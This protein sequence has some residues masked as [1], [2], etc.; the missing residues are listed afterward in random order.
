M[1]ERAQPGEGLPQWGREL[2]AK[3]AAAGG[4]GC[5]PP[6][7]PRQ[8]LDQGFGFMA[9]C[10]FCNEWRQVDLHRLIRKGQANRQ[11][12]GRRLI[13]HRCGQQGVGQI[14]SVMPGR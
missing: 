8:I 2:L 13:C 12:T 11:V 7:T 4:G 14:R 1:P 9:H 6:V 3:K 5:D 10:R